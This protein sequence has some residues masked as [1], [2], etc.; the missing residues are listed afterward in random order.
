MT[1]SKL[2]VV[3][4]HNVSKLLSVYPDCASAVICRPNGHGLPLAFL[5]VVT[6]IELNKIID[7]IL[8][9]WV[10]LLIQF[11]ELPH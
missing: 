2:A 9:L 6:S 4:L 11:I 5:V 10:M 7:A 3:I 8:P 1:L